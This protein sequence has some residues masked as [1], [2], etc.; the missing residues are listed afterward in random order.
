MT[1]KNSMKFERRGAK[2]MNNVETKE[3]NLFKEAPVTPQN[4]RK[5]TRSFETSAG[6]ENL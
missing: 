1:I 6:W 5:R 3:N 4:A 2:I